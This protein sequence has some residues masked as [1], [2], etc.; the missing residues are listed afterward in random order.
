VLASARDDAEGFARKVALFEDELAAEHRVRE[1]SERGC[2]EQFEKLT[3]R[4]SRGSELCHAIISPPRPRHHL[5]EGMRIATLRHT[6]MA[7]EL[8]ALWAVVTTVVESVLWRS[9]NDTFRV[10][11]VSEVA[12]EFQKAE[13]RRSRLERPAVR[14]CDLLL[15]PLP[16]HT[17]LADR[18]YEAVG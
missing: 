18:L 16:G 11:V 2:Q 14:V 4:H 3:L 17:R 15:G 12:T 7:G 5:S 1:V 9:P 10:E 6:E 13:D 8:A